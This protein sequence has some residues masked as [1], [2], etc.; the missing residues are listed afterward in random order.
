MLTKP[1]VML[2]VLAEPK[3][4]L[5]LPNTSVPAPL[6]VKPKPPETTPESVSPWTTAALEPPLTLKVAASDRVVVPANCS[7]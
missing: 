1:P 2:I 5:A 7:P 6:L 3:E 4:L